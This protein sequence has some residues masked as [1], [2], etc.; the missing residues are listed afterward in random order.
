MHNHVPFPCNRHVNIWIFLV[1]LP[2]DIPKYVKVLERSNITEIYK[3][4][5][6][7]TERLRDKTL[8]GE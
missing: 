2:L 7:D 6:A 4:A 5:K 3:Q 1:V 8:V